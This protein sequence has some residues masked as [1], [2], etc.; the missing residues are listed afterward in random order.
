MPVGVVK[1]K[2]DEAAW[3]RAKG[4]VHKQYPSMSEDNDSFWKIVQTIYQNMSKA[5][6]DINEDLLQKAAE[7][8]FLCPEI[9][10]DMRSFIFDNY[11]LLHTHYDNL[12]KS[13]KLQGRTDFQGLKIS[14]ENKKGSVRKWYDPLKD[15]SGETKMKYPYGYIRLTEG[16]DGD[17]VDCYLGGDKEAGRVYVVHQN[18]PN[19]GKYDEDKVMLG[20]NSAEEAKE[21]YLMHFDDPKFFGSIDEYNIETFKKH[22][23]RKKGKVTGGEL[24]KAVTVKRSL[25]KEDLKAANLRWVTVRGNHVLV[26]GLEDGSWVVVGGA[27]GKLAHFKIDKLL[28]EE[29]YKKKA[30]K[31]KMEKLKELSPEELKEQAVK[32]K[33]EIKF[34]KEARSTYE[35]QIREV[36]GEDFK[37]KIKAEEMDEMKTAAKRSVQKKQ[38]KEDVEEDDVEKEVEKLTRKEELKKIKEAENQAM[39]ILAAEFLGDDIE[40]GDKN[41]IRKL[42]DI[43]DAKKILGARKQFKRK[44]KELN[45]PKEKSER[46]YKIG[47]TFAANSKSI[48]EDIINEVKQH[49]ETQKN[50][51]LYDKLNAQSLGIQT[52]VDE[53]SLSTLNGL[54]GDLFGIGAVFSKETIE[55]LGLEACVRIIASRLDKEGKRDIA[56]EALLRYARKTNVKMVDKALKESKRRFDYADTIRDMAED[57]NDSEGILSKASANGYALR[58]I[59]A[60]QKALG[61]AVGSLRATAHL[62]NALDEPHTGPILVDMGEDLS[63][64]RKKAKKA[65]FKRNEYA[66][67]SSEKR[68][69]MEIPEESLGKFFATNED[70]R[71][72]ESKIDRIKKKEENTGYKP[73]GMASEYKDPRTGKMLPLKLDSAQEAGL[74]FFAEKGKVIL[75]F[76]AGLGK[77]AVAYA[78]AMEAMSNM[79]V[80]KVLIVVPAKLRSQMHKERKIFLDEENQK[81][82]ILNDKLMED[83]KRNYNVDEGIVI[84]GQDQ[85]RT[86]AKSIK[87]AGFGMIVIDEIHEMTNPSEAKE[88]DSGRYR[89]MMSLSDIPYKIGMSGTNIKNSKKELYKKINFI[90]PDHTLGSM[91]DFEGRYKGLN[92]GTSAFEASANDA[93]RREVAPWMYTQKTELSVK[94]DIEE[95]NIDLTQAQRKLYK[96]SENKYAKDKGR[97]GAASRRES[98][99]YKIIHNGDPATNSKI[100]TVI[101]KMDNFHSGEKAVIH[102]VRKSGLRSTKSALEKRYGRGSTAVIDGDSSKSHVERVK[103]EFN[104][105]D[106]KLRFILGTKSL[107]N[108]HNLQYGGTVNFHLDL[109]PT[110]SSLEQRNKR[111]HRK[112]QDRDVKTY[113]LTSNTP[114]DFS[115]KDILERKEREMKILGNPRHIEKLDETGFLVE[116]NQVMKE[117]PLTKSKGLPQGTIKEWKGIRYKKVAGKWKRIGKGKAPKVVGKKETKLALS[118]GKKAIEEYLKKSLQT[119]KEA[120]TKTTEC[121]VI[122]D[123][124]A[125]KRWGKEKAIETIKNANKIMRVLNKYVDLREYFKKAPSRKLSIK[126]VPGL[127]K[128][129][130]IGGQYQERYNKLLIGEEYTDSVIHEVGHYLW[131]K[132]SKVRKEFMEW[133]KESGYSARV[134]HNWKWMKPATKESYDYYT[135]PN[136]M[137]ARAF[138]AYI[139]H[140]ATA[141]NRK[142]GG[143]GVGSHYPVDPTADMFKD[144]KFKK[145]MKRAFGKEMIKAME[146]I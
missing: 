97:R 143:R 112:G 17:H 132:R 57:T 86:D 42:L 20:F 104:D 82:V 127:S 38:N 65:G 60:G 68:L 84:I 73:P 69:V 63:R 116:L 31:R 140:R 75:D 27:G 87:A 134:E 46:E 96:E 15:E 30:K 72:Q 119:E 6:I 93:F 18:N 71:T 1:T 44:I 8:S 137:F 130:K 80:K 142:I 37:A 76:E 79:G 13:W 105:P 11:F 121:N 51:Q 91:K 102:A 126:I 49:V 14:I 39:N 83:R 58:Q 107:E 50:I 122:M 92:Q 131:H 23:M 120:L 90:D 106:N 19:T 34:K 124:S 70:M 48:D 5:S 100:S 74:R 2:R 33:E 61:T 136:E 103:A 45:L 118:A 108:G 41:K 40:P 67:R 62:V 145:I 32:R 77:T 59:V 35:A 128:D 89:G 123:A 78:G 81:K 135:S 138:S 115:K 99:N 133:A 141:D 98:R 9:P 113:I 111:T 3:K 146:D 94:N 29:E 10:K 26:Q 95:V 43:D 64:A 47:Y 125:V 53:G 101:E 4:I 109:P 36:I 55:T 88:G 24:R 66:M 16:A 114:F 22:V 139:I 12:N 21:A 7:I 56:K 144:D 54:M 52:Q 85:L 129:Q 25:S 117:E 110:Y 28:S